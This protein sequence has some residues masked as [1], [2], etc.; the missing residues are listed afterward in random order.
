MEADRQ[1]EVEGHETLGDRMLAAFER[2][3]QGL[4]MSS[5]RICTRARHPAG[6]GE[7]RISRFHTID[8]TQGRLTALHKR[9]SA[10]HSS[11]RSP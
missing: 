10:V 6:R 1:D 9:W 4:S 3:E 2:G 5:L 7:V 8:R 11:H